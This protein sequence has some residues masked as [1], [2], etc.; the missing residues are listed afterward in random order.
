MKL[1]INYDF[2]D[3][4]RNVNEPLTPM[5]IIRNN[6]FQYAVY[7]PIWFSLGYF[8]WKYDI[9]TNIQHVLVLTGIVTSADIF[10]DYVMKKKFNVDIYADEASNKLKKLSTML[11]DIN[12]KTTYDMLLQSELYEHKY[13]VEKNE[14]K[15]P[16]LKEEKYIYVPSYG[17]DGEEKETS[18]LQE[19]NIGSRTYMLSV[20]EPEKQYKRVLVN[21]HA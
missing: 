13:K 4:V 16:S 2:F 12:V 11:A 7:C 8:C 10:S 17:F 14:D 19:H 9:M 18:V 3:A 20:G 21:N 15:L 6:R 1:L 5:K